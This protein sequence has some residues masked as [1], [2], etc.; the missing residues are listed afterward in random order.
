MGN[1]KPIGVFDS[2]IGGLTVVR[3]MLKEMPGERII[4]L[5]DT[6]RYPYGSRSEQAI[7]AMAGECA[8]YLVDRDVKMMVVACNTATAYAFEHLKERFRHIPFVGVIEPCTTAV[9]EHIREGKV[10]IIGTEGTIACGVYER[11]IRQLC[12]AIETVAR[13][14]PLLVPLAEEG[15]L[16][17]PIL[18]HVLD[19]YLRPLKKSGIRALILACTHYP[20]FRKKI[21]RYFDDKVFV[22]DSASWT[23]KSVQMALKMNFITSGTGRVKPGAHRFLVTDY[24]EKFRKAAGLFLGQDLAGVE[25]ISL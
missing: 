5:G 24:P 23:A 21:E 15:V 19:L 7:R 1:R 12:P 10:G 17:G 18:D 6:A 22:L 25:K 20:F 16:D 4:Y 9:A 3:E 13:A 2:G 8:G 11:K 14:C